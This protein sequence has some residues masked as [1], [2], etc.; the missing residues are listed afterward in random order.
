MPLPAAT[1]WQRLST[2]RKATGPVPRPTG[3]TCAAAGT[4]VLVDAGLAV[5]K[6]FACRLPEDSVSATHVAVTVD[7][8]EQPEPP[9]PKK[10]KPEPPSPSGVA[11]IVPTNSKAR[12]LSAEEIASGLIKQ[13]AASHGTSRS[14]HRAKAL[15]AARCRRR[16][17]WG[18][19]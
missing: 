14:E 13:R 19:R 10:E 3:F 12:A 1:A 2:K 7:H 11:V 16:G 4:L 5:V 8:V 17:G 9:P 15:R 18:P 6:N